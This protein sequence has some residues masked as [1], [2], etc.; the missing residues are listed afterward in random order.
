MKL[1]GSEL[2]LSAT[3]LSNFLGCRHRTGLDPG[4]VRGK[5]KPPYSPPHPLLQ[6][7]W[8]RGLE[9]EARYVE[10]LKTSGCAVTSLNEYDDEHRDEHVGRT[11]EAM[12][13]GM[14]AIVQGALRD[15]QWFGRP[16]VLRR[17]PAPSVFGSWSYEV[18]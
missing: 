3:D 11:L 16:D 14:E 7:L 15:G 4:A 10:S 18:V 13:C 8:A 2:E 17:V 1:S 9:H 5:R 12:R 6:L